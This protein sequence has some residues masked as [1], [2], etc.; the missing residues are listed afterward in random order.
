MN[1]DF[2][3]IFQRFNSPTVP[4]YYQIPNQGQIYPN[5]PPQIPI[6][7]PLYNYQHSFQNSQYNVVY[8]L[9]Q[10]V[11]G[12]SQ[13]LATQSNIPAQ[14]GP[15]RQN[16]PFHNKYPE[17]PAEIKKKIYKPNLAK[18]TT[19][20]PRFKCRNRCNKA[21][22][23]VCLFSMIKKRPL[24]KIEEGVN[25]VNNVNVINIDD[26]DDVED[27]IDHN[28]EIVYEKPIVDE[29]ENFFGQEFEGSALMQLIL[30]TAKNHPSQ[31]ADLLFGFSHADFD[32]ETFFEEF[33][34]SDAQMV[35]EMDLIL[36][37]NFSNIMNLKQKDIGILS[38]ILTNLLL[39]DN[40]NPIEEQVFRI[41]KKLLLEESEKIPRRLI[42][43]SWNVT[44]WSVASIFNLK[45][46]I[47]MSTT[48]K[49]RSLLISVDEKNSP[50]L[51]LLVNISN[52]ITNGN[53]PVIPRNLNVISYPSDLKKL[54]EKKKHQG[55][56]GWYLLRLLEV[57]ISIDEPELL[58]KTAFQKQLK[59][60]YT[61]MITGEEFLSEQKEIFRQIWNST[62]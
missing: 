1:S 3:N 24:V 36:R 8:S 61:E 50:I 37:K 58:L 16:D 35:S 7:S 22:H 12:L 41:F 21:D 49:V 20:T 34:L 44:G 47:T 51:S 33:E 18:K 43:F 45:S 5:L 26:V 56:S 2:S 54:L 25:D 39:K 38:P 13:I 14:L 55:S 40:R 19:I 6:Q 10:A 23:R 60:L 28:T 57:A 32:H 9:F 15:L 29:L 11:Q 17:I 62:T 53:N 30:D 59:E 52:E 46:F 4:Q 42:V 48:P 27:G 31:L